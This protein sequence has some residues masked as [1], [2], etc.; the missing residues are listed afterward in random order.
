[1]LKENPPLTNAFVAEF[2]SRLQG[3]G[4]TLV[5]ALTWFEQR[6]AEQGQTIEQVFQVASQ[7]QA[8]HQVS[9]GNSIGSLRFLGATDWRDF[10]EDM[11]VVERTLAGDPAAVYPLMDFATRD[12]YRHAVEQV[13]KLSTFSE[14]QVARRAVELAASHRTNSA[15]PG[16]TG[17]GVADRRAHVGYFLVDRGRRTLER[18]A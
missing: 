1:M 3:Q 2:G 17:E 9:I 12:R 16:Q 13:A 10:V 6:L 15:G 4:P 7:S 18:E 5:L 11:S 14:E 8:S